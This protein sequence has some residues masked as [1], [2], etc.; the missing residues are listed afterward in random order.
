LDARV[1]EYVRRHAAAAGL[2]DALARAEAALQRTRA[3]PV[4]DRHQR[5]LAGEAVAIATPS[6]GHI[7]AQ[8]GG[9][10]YEVAD[11]REK[12]RAALFDL[13]GVDLDLLPPVGDSEAGAGT[14]L[15][16]HLFHELA[17]EDATPLPSFQDL[18]AWV[19]DLRF[20]AN[21]PDLTPAEQWLRDFAGCYL[22]RRRDDPDEYQYQPSFR[23][24]VRSRLKRFC[25]SEG[26]EPRPVADGGRFG[27]L[28]EAFASLTRERIAVALERVEWSVLSEWLVADAAGDA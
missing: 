9:P 21:D 25:E 6:P 14:R 16:R 24:F 13:L 10:A 12:V 18:L 15:V 1:Y 27:S 20:R 26:W 5:Q 3:R 8:A 23:L 19:D 22:R 11:L 28:G 4:V 2:A 17:P 7:T